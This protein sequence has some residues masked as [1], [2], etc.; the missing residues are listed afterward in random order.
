MYL[1]EIYLVNDNG[2]SAAKAKDYTAKLL[3]NQKI[4]EQKL[5]W[6][7]VN[8]II[9]ILVVIIFAIIFQWM[10]KRKYTK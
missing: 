8:I 5:F 10:R 1:S 3:D 9:P 4:N 7:I 2:L 6:Q